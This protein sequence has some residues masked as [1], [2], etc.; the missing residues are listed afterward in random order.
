MKLS[1]FNSK[2]SLL[3]ACVAYWLT[4]LTPDLDLRSEIQALPVALFP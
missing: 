2:A 4:P 1:G 3:E